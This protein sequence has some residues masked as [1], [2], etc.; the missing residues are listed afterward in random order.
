MKSIAEPIFLVDDNEIYVK[1][2]EKYLKEHLGP[3]TQT[4]TFLNGEECLKH[5]KIKPKIVILDYFLN[6]TFPKAMNGL[7][8]LKQIKQ[9]SPETS[10]LMLSSQDNIQ[11]ATDT[12][13]YG[14]FDY[15]SKGDNAFIRV[16]NAIRNMEKMLSQAFA[17]KAAKQVK[18]VLIGWIGILIIIIIVLQLF[19]PQ[20]M[21]SL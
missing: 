18:L 8:V 16:H 9:I 15:V 17:L 20:F 11:V 2:L 21:S 10:V 7:E 12:M 14:A 13:K 6:T 4:K 5:M 19:F 3:A 1:T